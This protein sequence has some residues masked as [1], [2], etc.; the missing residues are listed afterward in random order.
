MNNIQDIIPDWNIMIQNDRTTVYTPN[1][2]N[3]HADLEFN[4]HT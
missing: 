4:D 2:L 1:R 3:K